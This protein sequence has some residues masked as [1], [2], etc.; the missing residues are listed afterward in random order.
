VDILANQ[1][2]LV[3]SERGKF[4]LVASVQGYVRFLRERAVSGDLKGG[5]EVGGLRTRMIRART[6]LA[7]SEAEAAAGRML[8]RTD[9]ET[10]WQR[11][12]TTIRTRILALPTR[13]APLLQ[14]AA[15]PGEASSIL[16]TAV[17]E[18]LADLARTPVYGRSAARGAVGAHRNGESSAD[19]PGA[20]ADLDDSAVG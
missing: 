20:A 17:H 10:A 2:V 3:R 8:L 9:V 16:T 7:E 14:S 6:E 15:T 18:A 4:E 11:I 12:T 5:D 13:V 19:D 1:G